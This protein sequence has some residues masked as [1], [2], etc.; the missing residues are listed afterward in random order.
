VKTGRV[1]SVVG[2]LERDN[3]VKMKKKESEPS[4]MDDVLSACGE[5]KGLER[6]TAV[7]RLRLALTRLLVQASL[8]L[9]EQTDG[10]QQAS[11]E[12]HHRRSSFSGAHFAGAGQGSVAWVD[13]AEGG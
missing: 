3:V 7:E 2:G 12:L 4:A 13:R 8:V 5:K 6:C 1:R 9:R 11:S 10:H